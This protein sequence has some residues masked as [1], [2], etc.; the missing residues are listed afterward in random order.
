MWMKLY[1][2]FLYLPRT[3]A[4]S[5]LLSYFHYL[6]YFQYLT[7]DEIMDSQFVCISIYNVL[8]VWASLS[9]FCKLFE[10]VDGEGLECSLNRIQCSCLFRLV[11]I[12]VLF[13]CILF[14]WFTYLLWKISDI[15]CIFLLLDGAITLIFHQLGD[16]WWSNLDSKMPMIFR[17]IYPFF[18][19]V[20][21]HFYT[22][23]SIYR[24]LHCRFWNCKH[25]S[26]YLTPPWS[27]SIKK[28]RCQPCVNWTCHMGPCVSQRLRSCLPAARI[29]HMLA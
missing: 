27:P 3:M 9:V 5:F 2:G 11:F 15:F 21:L 26:I 25:A 19:L 1:K 12:I 28:V 6:D 13:L 22:W 29:S 20:H 4:F 14:L 18:F 16:L 10:G 24:I 7:C 17:N 8:R 23:F